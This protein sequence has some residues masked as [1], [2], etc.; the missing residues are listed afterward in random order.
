MF[1]RMRE[2]IQSVFHRDPAARNAFEVLT[3]YPGLHA[4]W[5]HRLSHWLWAHEWKWLARMS[6]N[7][8]RWLTGV[9]IH[10]GARIGRRFF[11]DHGMGIVIGET[12][13]IGDDVTL[14]HGVT[15]GGTSWN[16]GKRH[17]TLEDGVIV[18]AG[19][20]ILG[21]FTVGAGAKIGSNAVVTREV[22]PGATAVG[23]PG[24][25]IVKS[26]DEQEARRKAI[27]EK[28]GF[29]AYGVSE[30][31]P[32]PVA[33]AIGQLLDHVQ[34]VEERLEGMCGALKALGSDYC[35]KELPELREEDFV[36]VKSEGGEPR[37]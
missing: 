14:Y 3:C 17:P 22:P 34:A 36:E 29:D 20:K 31:M 18:G 37:A 28:I 23:I 33:R 5:I 32:D 24:R 35:A 19:A 25:I 11:I 9:E 10:P 26:S 7:L 6:S 12:A 8:G 4:V 1:E 13:E 15:L 27:A 2:D 21:P 16:K 30:D